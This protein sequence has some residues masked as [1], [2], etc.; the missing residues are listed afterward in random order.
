MTTTYPSGA[1]NLVG[2]NLASG[3]N[4]FFLPPGDTSYS[5][6]RVTKT[7]TGAPSQ[8][9]VDAGFKYLERRKLHHANHWCQ[10]V[11]D[12]QVMPSD[13]Y[14][15]CASTYAGLGTTTD[16]AAGYT[17]REYGIYGLTPDMKNNALFGGGSSPNAAAAVYQFFNMTFTANPSNTQTFTM[18]GITTTWTTNTVTNTLTQI[19]V[20]NSAA[21][22]ATN[23]AN[24][25][26]LNA[27][28][29]YGNVVA[30]ATNNVLTFGA[31]VQER[32]RC[33][34]GVGVV[35]FSFCEWSHY[36]LQSVFQRLLHW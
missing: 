35:Y 30:T 10:H 36:V 11:P 27:G 13:A 28:A 12:V 16:S 31:N 22:A 26:N 29:M 9:S 7:G 15:W 4:L 8:I 23:L 6:C 18:D 14:Y 3:A 17:V 21:A 34:V 25:M 2:T 19:A 33:A 24:W 32:E 5:D 20:T 1:T